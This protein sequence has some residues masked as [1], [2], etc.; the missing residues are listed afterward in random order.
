MGSGQ[1]GAS[2]TTRSA[3]TMRWPWVVLGSGWGVGIESCSEMSMP[4][5]WDLLAESEKRVEASGRRAGGCRKR[6]QE[7]G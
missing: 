7:P 1:I 3:G 6:S 4:A 2:V 5:Q